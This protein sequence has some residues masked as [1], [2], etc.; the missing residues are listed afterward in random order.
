MIYEPTENMEL[1]NKELVDILSE[2]IQYLRMEVKNINM[3]S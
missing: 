2:R 1:N 3:T